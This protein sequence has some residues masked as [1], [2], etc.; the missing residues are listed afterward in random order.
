MSTVISTLVEEFQGLSLDD[1]EYAAEIINKQLLESRREY[2]ASRVAEAR[3]NYSTGQIKSG[4]FDEL[5]EDLEN[6]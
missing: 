1:Q 4:S 3:A 6:D 2:L 5:M